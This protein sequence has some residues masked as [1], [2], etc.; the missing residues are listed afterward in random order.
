[1]SEA[2]LA[3]LS[4]ADVLASWRREG[5]HLQDPVRFHYMEVLAERLH[6]QNG[7]VRHVLSD[8]LI[9][10]Q[11]AFRNQLTHSGEVTGGNPR[12]L[13]TPAL[14]TGYAALVELNRYIRSATVVGVGVQVS[15]EAD[16]HPEMK[17]VRHF[18]HAWSRIRAQD[19][20]TKAVQQGPENP[21]PL[22]SHRLVLRS[23]SL[24]QDLSPDY[25]QRFLS[26]TESLLWLDQLTVKN[27]AVDSKTTR[28][29]RPKK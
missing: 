11:A 15:G 3:E 26:H 14:G 6:T 24:M 20:V 13:P 27:A 23:L 18:K 29:G 7:A 21:G 19:Q 2:E 8:K 22:N 10:A 9:A 28:R 4:P 5:C 17:S 25:L 1:M 12:R 16:A